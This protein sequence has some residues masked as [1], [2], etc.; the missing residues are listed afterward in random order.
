MKK[1]IILI[2]MASFLIASCTVSK[3]RSG[4]PILNNGAAKGTIIGGRV[5]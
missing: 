3:A 5:R 4:C 1:I 2:V